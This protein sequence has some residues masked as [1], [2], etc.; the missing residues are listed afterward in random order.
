MSGSTRER[1]AAV[2]GLWTSH[3][4]AFLSTLLSIWKAPSKAWLVLVNWKE[5][6]VIIGRESCSRTQSEWGRPCSL[7]LGEAKARAVASRELGSASLHLD[8]SGQP[9]GLGEASIGREETTRRTDRTPRG[10]R[11]Q[12]APKEPAG[13]W[14]TRF[15]VLRGQPLTGSHNRWRGRIAVS[16]G[17]IVAGKSRLSREGAKEPWPGSRRVRG[18][19]S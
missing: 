9:A 5:L 3:S 4:G 13:T 19:W 18:D 15:G 7:K 8:G 17:L 6:I 14:E 11:R 10:E 16:D 2:I 12:R 1:E